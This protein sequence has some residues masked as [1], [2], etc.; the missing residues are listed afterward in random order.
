MAR[1]LTPEQKLANQLQRQQELM[2]CRKHTHL[3]NERRAKAKKQSEGGT[4]HG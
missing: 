3:T 1:K 4:Q 2:L